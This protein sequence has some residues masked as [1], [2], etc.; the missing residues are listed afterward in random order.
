MVKEGQKGY[1]K[2]IL[3]YSIENFAWMNQFYNKE[4]RNAS[5][6]KMDQVLGDSWGDLLEIYSGIFS[7][8]TF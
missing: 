3:L 5:I 7:W 4:W 2:D 8:I 6:F 1:K